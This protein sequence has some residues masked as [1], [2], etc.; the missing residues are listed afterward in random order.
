M[1]VGKSTLCKIIS[2]QLSYR[3]IDNDLDMAA[4]NGL[5]I[6]QLSSIPIPELHQL[7]ANFIENVLLSNGPL[8]ILCQEQKCVLLWR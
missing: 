3:N 1:G 2:K 7:E 8:I 5:T 6:D 4:V